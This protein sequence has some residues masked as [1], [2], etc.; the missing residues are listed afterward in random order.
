MPWQTLPTQIW[1]WLNG[2][3]PATVKR[4]TSAVWQIEKLDVPQLQA[5]ARAEA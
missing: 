4:V 5:A 1:A 3:D 2:D